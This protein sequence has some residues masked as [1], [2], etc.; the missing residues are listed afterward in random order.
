[1]GS[2]LF[3]ILYIYILL[4][5]EV[6][7][8][9]LTRLTSSNHTVKACVSP[10]RSAAHQLR[11]RRG[12]GRLYYYRVPG[13]G[14]LCILP[15]YSA[16]ASLILLLHHSGA[17]HKIPTWFFVPMK[18]SA[19]VINGTIFDYFTMLCIVP[20][21]GASQGVHYS[22]QTWTNKQKQ[23]YSRQRFSRSF[24]CY[25]WLWKAPKIVLKTIQGRLQFKIHTQGLTLFEMSICTRRT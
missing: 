17:K 15:H 10:L 24:W 5:P 2:A 23:Q 25:S 7:E 9:W 3:T 19:A 18:K 11:T 8:I 12:S 13:K 21:L 1:M 14:R 20:V 22:Q 4:V 6:A 16:A